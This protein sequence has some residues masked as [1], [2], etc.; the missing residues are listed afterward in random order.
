MLEFVSEKQSVWERLK[1]ETRPIVLYGMGNGADKILDVFNQ[2]G[3]PCAGVFASDEFVR[4]QLFHGHQVISYS[5]ACRL[6]GDF[7]IVLAFGV[8]RPD[9][10]KR[11]AQLV[12]E[13]PLYAPDVPVYGN[14]LFTIDYLE[15]HEQE[16]QSVYDQLT[17]SQSKRV[18][19]HV[20][21]F[22]ISGNPDWLRSAE[23]DPAE[24]CRQ[25]LTPEPG[26]WYLDLGAYNGDSI[27]D[28]LALASD[29]HRIMAVEPDEKNFRKLLAWIDAA[30]VQNCTAYH[31]AIWD[32]PCRLPFQSRAGRSSSRGKAGDETVAADSIDHLLGEAPVTW[33]KMDVEG[34]ETQALL[35]G[36]ETLR[37]QRPKLSVAVYHRS[38][39]LFR[40]PLLV[41]QLCPDYRLYLRHHPYIPAWETLLY[42]AP[43]K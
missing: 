31:A 33:I 1:R 19:A 34:A 13:H 24:D 8:Y 36:A 3:I 30:A 17:D 6:Y 15:K 16:I 18:F 38:G 32:H 5:D 25:I 41:K 4:G 28:F 42:C 43:V 2:E 39:D 40:L 29:Y 9:M 14:E 11:I 7:V 23:S 27:R 35:G 12:E 37:R 21:N 22:K 26:E 10:L 20:I